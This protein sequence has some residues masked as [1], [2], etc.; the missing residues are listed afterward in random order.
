MSITARKGELFNVGG[1]L[2]PEAPSYVKRPA[3]DEL[4][5]HV[6]A[7]QFCYVLTSRQ[8]GK[9]SLMIRTAKW[10][11]QAGVKTAMIDLS[12]LGT[13][14]TSKQ[15]YLG[16]LKRLEFELN[17]PIESEQWW[18]ERDALSA[19]QRFTDFL[20]NVVLAEIEAR[21][22]IFFDE[23][24]STLKLSFTDDFFAAIR[25]MYN[26]RADHPKYERLTFVLLGVAAPTDLIKDRNR[27]PFNIGRSINL[28]ELSRAD[29]QPLQAG[30]K[31]VSP[32]QEARILDHI[33]FWTNG[34]PYLTQKICLGIAESSADDWPNNRIDALVE[35]LFLTEAAKKEDNLQFVRSNIEASPERRQL[36]R[37]YRPVYEGKVVK[38]DERSLLQNRL[39]LIGLVRAKNRTLHLRNEIYRRVFNLA[40]IKEN[41]PVNWT[42]FVIVGAVGISILAI[43]LT[44]FVIQQQKQQEIIIQVK[45]HADNFHR[46][47]DTDVRLNSLANLCRLEKNKKAQDL[48][49]ELDQEQ[50]LDMFHKV[51]A[52]RAGEKLVA[53]VE[54]LYPAVVERIETLEDRQALSTEMCCALHRLNHAEGEQFSQQ[55]GYNCSCEAK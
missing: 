43:L 14:L 49:F 13:Q 26:R 50:Q 5:T 27:T 18:R 11:R 32:G 29:A 6:R 35:S 24:D 33:F 19:V 39:K 8:M 12:G 20:N 36:M 37:I 34:H 9:S 40:W 52:K 15:W 53:A 10:L 22:V 38:E 45:T 1:T 4:F 17:L 3:D 42:Q 28:Q 21:I 47:S 48:F 55:I 31:Q 46:S 2:H 41:T 44:I 25:G 16:L 51:K 7:G 54:C 30:L 23:I